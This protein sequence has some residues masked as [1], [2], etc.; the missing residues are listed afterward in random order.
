MRVCEIFSSVQGESTY[1]GLSCT[2]IRLSGCNLRCKYCDTTYAYEGGEE[3]T[4]DELADEAGKRG[5][6]L[7][8]ITGGEP[9][10]QEGVRELITRLS[11]EGFTVLLETNGSVGI[12]GIDPRATVIMDVKTPGSGMAGETD[13]ANL[14]FLKPSDEVKF[15]L[16]DRA[17]YEWARDFMRKHG[18]QE[19]CK[20]LLSPVFGVL[21]PGKLAGWMLR[22]GLGARLNLQLHKYVFGS[23]RRGV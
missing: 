11:D 5:I 12:K 19:K 9:L 17:D 18:L 20:A 3:Y 6:G 16:T 1:A 15:V 13:L 22:D 14:G 4:V 23:Q 21:D 7:V 10:L 2:F 8:E